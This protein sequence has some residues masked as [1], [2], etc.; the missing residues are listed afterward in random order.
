MHTKD[1]T[2]SE[3]SFGIVGLDCALALYAKA[4]VDD[5]VLDWPKMLLMM[6]SNPATLINRP[7]LGVLALGN[8][9]DITIIDPNLDWTIDTRI[10]ASTARNCPFD[11]WK[12]KGKAIATIFGGNLGYQLLGDRQNRCKTA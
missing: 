3:A 8:R 9:A 1:K 2:F 10:F 12:V 6:T 11:G 7:E 4:L 5:G